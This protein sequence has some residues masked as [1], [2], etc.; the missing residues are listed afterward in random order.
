MKCAPLHS[1]PEILLFTW[2]LFPQ[3]HH[4]V[5][6]IIPLDIVRL[7][8]RHILTHQVVEEF[9]HCGVEEVEL[10]GKNFHGGHELVHCHD[11]ILKQCRCV[12]DGD[13]FAKLVVRV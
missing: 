8:V 3:L 2:V 1:D 10:L 6:E 12:E 9:A 11:Q 5:D 7:A 13:N 4:D